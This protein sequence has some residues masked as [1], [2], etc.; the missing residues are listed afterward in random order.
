M[1]VLEN[2][3]VAQHNKLMVASGMTIFGMLGLRGYRNAEREAAIESARDWLEEIGLVDRADD[4]AADLPYGAQRRLEIA[5]AMCTEPEL[6]CL[7]EPAAGLNPHESAEL[8]ELLLRI[9]DQHRTSVL[10]I[11]HDMSRGDG[12]LR[13]HRRARIRHQD[14]RRHA[15]GGAQRSEGHR[16]LSRRRGRGGRGGRTGPR[17]IG[18]R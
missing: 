16:R 13:P 9:R 5:R 15:G 14:L 4:P 17:R 3:L 8:N 1:T 18:A 11:E 6:L 12:D 7:D 10:L 2:L